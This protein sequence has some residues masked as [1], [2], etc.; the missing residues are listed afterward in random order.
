MLQHIIFK[1]CS[2]RIICD[3]PIV[4]L[5]KYIVNVFKRLSW[6]KMAQTPPLLDVVLLA[7]GGYVQ[8]KGIM[9]TQCIVHN[10]IP[11]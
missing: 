3:F 8:V 9:K 10:Y 6:E 4:M 5:L 11:V 2:I 7:H 1:V